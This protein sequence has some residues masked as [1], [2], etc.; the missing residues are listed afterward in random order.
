MESLTLETNK[1]SLFL[2][3][4]QEV[5]ISLDIAIQLGISESVFTKHVI[6]KRR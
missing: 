3:E 1:V 4:R 5:M 2:T 6:R